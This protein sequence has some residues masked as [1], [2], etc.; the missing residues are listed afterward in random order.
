MKTIRGSAL[1]AEKVVE[2]VVVKKSA[3]GKKKNKSGKVETYKIYLCKVLKSVHPDRGVT[4]KAMSVLNSL[5]NDMFDRIATEAGRL[6]GYAKRQTLTARDIQTAVR[7]VLSGELAM[8]AV[9][10]GTKAVNK[11]TSA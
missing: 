3:D 1:L 2:K 11:F 4:S 7:L 10:E 8:H 5:V 9:S 6:V